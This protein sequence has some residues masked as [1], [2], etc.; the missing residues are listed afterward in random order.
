MTRT[1]SRKKPKPDPTDRLW[2]AATELFGDLDGKDLNSVRL[3]SRVRKLERLNKNATS[4]V[5]E[6]FEILANM[7]TKR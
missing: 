4:V 6:I 3:L 5:A 2:H 1:T 7:R